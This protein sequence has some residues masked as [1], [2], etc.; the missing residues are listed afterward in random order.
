MQKLSESSP[1]PIKGAVKTEADAYSPV[2][3]VR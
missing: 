2:G 3:G 1:D